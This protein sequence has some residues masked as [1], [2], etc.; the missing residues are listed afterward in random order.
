M[1]RAPLL[2][3]D[4]ATGYF[5][6]NPLYDQPAPDPLPIDQASRPHI[7]VNKLRRRPGADHTLSTR[8]H[9]PHEL[10]IGDVASIHAAAEFAE[11]SGMSLDMHVT[12][13]FARM[14]I[15]GPAEAKRALSQFT[16]RYNTWCHDKYLPAAWIACM[17]M[18]SRLTYHA[19]VALFVPGLL[20]WQD[21]ETQMSA[22]REF[23][24]WA[25]TYTDR[26]FGRHIPRAIW[27]RGGKR[28]NQIGHWRVVTYLMKGFDRSAILCSG[29][30][31]PDGYD[32]RLGDIVPLNYND[33][34]PVALRRRVFVSENLGPKQRRFGAPK[35]FEDNLPRRPNWE[36]LWADSSKMSPQYKQSARWTLPQPV[37]FRSVFEDSIW[38]VRKLYPRAFYEHVTGLSF[39]NPA[40]PCQIPDVT[41][42]E[43]PTLADQLSAIDI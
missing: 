28:E 35:G 26:N 11:W 12:I 10:S 33:P 18:S 8:S 1:L 32:I 19:H 16:H 42:C 24:R 21:G 3:V 36:M 30:N 7:F 9:P 34:G 37:P 41:I 2:A 23:R 40:G 29:R 38:D 13:D 17:E 4:K 39:E 43:F 25:R 6:I 22:R 5:D 27:V 15:S 31:S 20:D 14:G